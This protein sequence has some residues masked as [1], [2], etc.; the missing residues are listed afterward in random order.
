MLFQKQTVVL[1]TKE[2]HVESKPV[3]L[4]TSHNKQTGTHQNTNVI[5]PGMIPKSSET[6]F[7]APKT[8]FSEKATQSKTLDTTSVA[9]KSK[10]DEASAKLVSWSSKKQDCTAM[11]TAE[12]EYV[13]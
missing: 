6:T 2:N 12:A 4:Q 5:S 1:K 13:S 3:T 9:S 10:I 11:S 8:R 7:V